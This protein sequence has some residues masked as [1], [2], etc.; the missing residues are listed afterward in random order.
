MGVANESS[1]QRNSKSR[2]DTSGTTTTGRAWTVQE[3]RHKSWEDLHSLWWVCVRERNR[4]STE[5]WE[6]DRLK[7]GY[8][9]H[10]AGERERT[11]CASISNPS[12]P[13]QRAHIPLLLLSLV[14]LSHKKGNTS[15]R[16]K[17][18]GQNPERPHDS[19]ETRKAKTFTR[20]Y[21][22]PPVRPR[23]PPHTRAGGR[24]RAWGTWNQTAI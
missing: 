8:G 23:P 11:V 5:S 10:E 24:A 20:R 7:A 13:L 4:L 22:F 2:A 6:R 14:A 3:L 18:E 9:E 12:A 16:V 15:P 17:G 19:K 21:R 1:A